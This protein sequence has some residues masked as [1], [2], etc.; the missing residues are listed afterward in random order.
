MR[1]TFNLLPMQDPNLAAATHAAADGPRWSL[2]DGRLH[3][4]TAD[5]GALPPDAAAGALVARPKMQL[6]AAK[7]VILP[8][9]L[10]WYW[11]LDLCSWHTPKC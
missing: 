3:G 6:A 11:Q 8:A 5:A 1:P 2:L 9:L 7:G 4:G 10:L